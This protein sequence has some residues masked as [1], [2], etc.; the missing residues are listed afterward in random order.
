MLKLDLPRGRPLAR[1]TIASGEAAEYTAGFRRVK[2]CDCNFYRTLNRAE[3][4]T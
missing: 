2:P 3:D 4:A 1:H